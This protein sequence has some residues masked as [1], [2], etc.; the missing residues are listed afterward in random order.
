MYATVSNE[1]RA[2][3]QVNGK[4]VS[5]SNRSRPFYHTSPCPYLV[6]YEKR[7]LVF[8]RLLDVLVRQVGRASAN[9]QRSNV[10]LG[11]GT[12]L[13]DFVKQSSKAGMM[14][15]EGFANISR[16]SIVC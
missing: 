3:I 6:V 10:S 15:A 4:V 9:V 8:R 12:S 13:A 1:S 7:C 14:D 2:F 11:I 5:S 16:L